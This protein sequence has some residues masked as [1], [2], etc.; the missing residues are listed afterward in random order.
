MEESFSGWP[1]ITFSLDDS[2]KTIFCIY[3]RRLSDIS[4]KTT[5]HI[6]L[7]MSVYLNDLLLRRCVNVSVIGFR[8][9]LFNSKTNLKLSFTSFFFIK[10][11]KIFEMNGIRTKSFKT[12]THT[13]IFIKSC[14]SIYDFIETIN[15]GN[16]FIGEGW[17]EGCVYRFTY[18]IIFRALQ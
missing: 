9:N 2:D 18:Y 3:I 10:K 6:A 4:K 14:K 5:K 1:R 11:I 8:I 16:L 13:P 17:G 7:T 12:R 15:T